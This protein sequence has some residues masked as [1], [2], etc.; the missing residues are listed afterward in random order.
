M[1]KLQTLLVLLL[2]LVLLPRAGAALTV[3]NPAGQTEDGVYIDAVLNQTAKRDTAFPRTE[4]E[5]LADADD[6]LEAFNALFLAR[7][8]GDG[9]PL[10]PPTPE[11]VERM[12][13]GYDLP[14][15][16]PIATLAPM[17]GV[18]TVE[19]IAV[20]AVMAGCEPRHMPLLVAAVEAVSQPEFDLR[21]MSTTTNP[22]AVLLIVS[23]PVVKALGLNAAG[24]SFGRGNR[25]NA[26]ISRALH[27]IIQNVGGSR[28]GI[29]DMSTLGQ[30]GEFVMFLAENSEASPWPSWQTEFGFLPERSVVTAAAV[31]GYSGIM[32]IGYSRQEFLDLVAQ[33]LRG[34]D[35]PYRSAIILIIAQDTAKMLARE[36]WTRAS[37]RDYLRSR[38]R[39]PFRDWI[40][41][42]HG[43]KEARRGVPEDVLLTKDEDALIPKPFLDSLPILVAG[44]TGEKSM[45][46]PC[47]AAGRMVSVEIRLPYGWK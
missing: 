41:Q 5:S 27:L 42:Y 46:L 45:L 26:S 3:C 37:I 1:P 40:R 31:E 14:G 4:R 30:P 43:A 2:A 44:G 12:A 25:A 17:E 32:G 22:D 8:W 11:R 23:G 47:W 33:W 18:A 28:P 36:G 20:N 29:T 38:A 16:F 13:A 6:A 34:H 9:L 39:V 10:I 35:R 21:G 15:D 19:K 7:G 24:G